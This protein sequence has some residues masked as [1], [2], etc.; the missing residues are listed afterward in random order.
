MGECV[1]LQ[2]P[3]PVRGN[4]YFCYVQFLLLLLLFLYLCVVTSVSNQT[5]C[6]VP[7]LYFCLCLLS[8]TPPPPPPPPYSPRVP[9]PVPPSL[10]L[11]PLCLAWRRPLQLRNVVHGAHARGMRRQ[12][13][14]IGSLPIELRC[15]YPEVCVI[16][17][18]P[19]NKI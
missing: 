15:L 17:L 7:M 3:P 4:V 2:P 12:S 19:K 8:A 13:T 5:S 14:G 16:W 6:P 10:P 1:R 11:A 18:L 9:A